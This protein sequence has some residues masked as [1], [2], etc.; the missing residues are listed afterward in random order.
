MLGGTY[1]NAEDSGKIAALTGSRSIQFRLRSDRNQNQDV[2]V[3]LQEDVLSVTLEAIA[4]IQWS[5]LFEGREVGHGLLQLEF[6]F[7]KEN[8]PF[9]KIWLGE[10]R[11]N[12]VFH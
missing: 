11:R 7:E 10:R 3:T 12:L 9:K 6:A 2:S 5:G 4:L 8:S 1:L